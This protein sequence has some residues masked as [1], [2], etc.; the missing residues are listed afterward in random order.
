MRMNQFEMKLVNKW[1]QTMSRR[2]A[3]QQLYDLREEENGDPYKQLRPERVKYAPGVKEAEKRQK[4]KKEAEKQKPVDPDH[5]ILS[6]YTQIKFDGYSCPEWA[7]TK[8]ELQAMRGE[9]A[10]HYGVDSVVFYIGSFDTNEKK[11]PELKKRLF[12]P[13][14]KAYELLCRKKKKLEGLHMIV[15]DDLWQFIG[16]PDQLVW[17]ARECQECV[18]GL[19]EK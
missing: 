11:V 9:M 15:G 4:A 2:E 6:K 14:R 18:L 3:E 8:A 5:P 1:R 12:T 17:Y 13:N 10:K 19:G 16:L 7:L